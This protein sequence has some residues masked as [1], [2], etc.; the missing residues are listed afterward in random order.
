MILAADIGGTKIA[1]ALT[2]GGEVVGEV[3]TVPTPAQEGAS[4]V[5]EA[6]C[7]LLREV[8]SGAQP[9]A[10]G[11]S[12]AGVVVDG[13]I[14]AATSHIAGWAGTA[15]AAEV[16]S[17]LGVPVAA[18]NDGHAFGVGEALYGAGRGHETV[19]L[20]AVGTGIGGAI[21]R[22]GEPWLG[23]RGVAGHVGHVAVELA[24]GVP[25][26]CGATGHLEAV[27]GGAGMLRRYLDLGGD[28]S[29]A[30]ARDLFDRPGDPLAGS[31]V[32]ACAGAVGEALAGLA[33]AIDPDVVVV[34]G[35][36]AQ[37]GPAWESPV[38]AAFAAGLMPA[39]AGLEVVVSDGGTEMAL[40]G[41]ARFAARHAEARRTR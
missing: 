18:L 31:V 40:R 29:V 8:A 14:T 26:Y 6:V 13:R 21:V 30:S 41:A 28:P 33:N 3:V 37:A 12:C 39:L 1:A 17:V 10:V 35:G 11:L 7:E 15:V 23:S 20:A 16:E 27:A 32:A 24:H 34:A 5:L 4:A 2:D 22:R 36:L 19:L 25:C 9:S 38:R